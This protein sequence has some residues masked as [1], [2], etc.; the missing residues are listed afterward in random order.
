MV[1]GWL[2]FLV[3]TCARGAEPTVWRLEQPATI[4]GHA[5]R[6]VGEPRPE[7]GEGGPAIGFGGGRDGLFVPDN[8]LAGAETYTIEIRFRPDAGGA[9]AQ[10]F[11]HLQDQAGRRALLE[12]RLDGKGGWWLD[13]FIQTGEARGS[14]VTLIDPQRVH[15]VGRW[16]W[17]ALRYDGR[18]MAHFVE[19]KKEL[20]A[21]GRFV[22]FGPGSISLGVRQTLVYWFKGAIAEVRFH[23]EALPDDKLQQ[24][25]AGSR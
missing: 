17:V 7:R 19:G 5:N 9:E 25:S 21:P 24:H 15:S 10:R 2:A 12:T 6:V 22:P 1:F 11:F 4:A 20:E 18:V 3:A 14:G 13:T 23:R 16:Y 8:P